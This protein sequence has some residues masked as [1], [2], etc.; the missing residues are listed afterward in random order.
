[1]L[2]AVGKRRP[3]IPA[4]ARGADPVRVLGVDPGSRVTGWGLVGGSVAAPVLIEG[5]VIRMPPAGALAE[6]LALLQREFSGLIE[7]LSPTAAAVESPFHG[8]DSR[9][10]LQLAHARG[11]LLAA[12][13]AAGLDV[14]EYP[15]ATVKKAITGNGRAD[16]DQVCRMLAAQ[17]G[18]D[19]LQRSR[20]QTD[21]V[22]VALCHLGA[23]GLRAALA[24]SG[25]GAA[26]PRRPARRPGRR[27]ALR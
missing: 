1:M 24:R 19:M 13:A 27:E 3:A 16:K 15:P 10:A 20:D 4:R 25:G 12:L 5:G 2:A 7:R 18:P 21:A 9:A 11:V 17:L 14:A 26:R 6:R 23:Q 22:A 8:K